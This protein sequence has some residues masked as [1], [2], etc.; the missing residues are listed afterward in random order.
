MW[1]TKACR[2]INTTGF[3]YYTTTTALPAIKQFNPSDTTV[4]SVTGH[5][6]RVWNSIYS[7]E[8]KL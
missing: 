8:V 5:A 4:Y 6:G 7:N 2:V 3:K 1:G